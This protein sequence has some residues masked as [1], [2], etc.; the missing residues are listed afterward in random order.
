MHH[1]SNLIIRGVF[2]IGGGGGEGGS[3]NLGG[4]RLHL[5]PTFYQGRPVHRPGYASDH[6][7]RDVKLTDT[8]F[9]NNCVTKL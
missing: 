7:I 8:C 1:D 4:A 9:V 2:L 5:G 3:K 6:N